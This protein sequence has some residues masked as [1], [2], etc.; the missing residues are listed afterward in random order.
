ME[1]RQEWRYIYYRLAD[2]VA[3]LLSVNERFIE[4]LAERVAACGRPE[5]EGLDGRH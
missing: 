4:R 5:M 1:A 2:G 3:E